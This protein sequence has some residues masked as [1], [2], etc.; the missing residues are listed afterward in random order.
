MIIA[1]QNW[2]WGYV[3]MRAEGISPP[4]MTSATREAGDCIAR[5]NVP[6]F[7]QTDQS[8][9]L[10][11]SHASREWAGD[12]LNASPLR[13][14]IPEIFSL[15]RGDGWAAQIDDL[16]NKP[17]PWQLSQA[18]GQGRMSSRLPSTATAKDA[19][20]HLYVSE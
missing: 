17:R 7:A 18:G 11:A 13:P 15:A 9:R 6:R 20:Y 1:P 19:G 8:L 16:P 12:R 2:R 3:A 4:E 10:A 5:P 14:G